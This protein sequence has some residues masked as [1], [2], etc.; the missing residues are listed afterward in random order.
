M[1][2]EKT[3]WKVSATLVKIQQKLAR[4]L[5]CQHHLDLFNNNKNFVTM[6]EI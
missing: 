4:K 3:V 2:H 1:L 6:N 5:I